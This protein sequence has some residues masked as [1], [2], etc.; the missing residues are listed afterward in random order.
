MT[1]SR[2]VAFPEVATDPLL[3]VSAVPHRRL[4]RAPTLAPVTPLRDLARLRIAI[5]TESWRPNVDGVVTRLD[6]TVR[7]LREAGHEV[8]VVAPSID[9]A[10]EELV[11]YRTPTLSLGWLYG[12][13]PWAIPGRVVGRA[14]REFEPDVVHVVNPVLMGSLALQYAAKRYPTVVSYHTDVSVYASMYHLGWIR[15][16]LHEV[17]RR[18][19]RRADIRLATSDVGSRQLGDLRIDDVELW[20]RGVDLSLFRPGRDGTAMRDRLCP[21]PDRTLVLYVGRL[22]REKGCERLLDLARDPGPYHVALVGDGPDRARLEELFAGTRATFAGV[23][24][25]EDLADAY[26]AADVFVFP[27]ETDTLGLVLLE[28]LASG[29]PVVAT[30]SPAA[31]TVLGACPTAI[32]VPPGSADDALAAAVATASRLPREAEPASPPDAIAGRGWREATVGLVA[33][34]RQAHHR[35]RPPRRRRF[36]R[37]LAV[38]VSNAAVDLGVFNF[39]VFVHP[40]RAAGTN[41]VYNTVAVLAAIL[42]S[43]FW[44]SRWT[45][46]DRVT[47]GEGRWR[48]RALFLAQ[49]GINLAVS[50]GVI[51]GLSLLLGR[52]R[53]LPATLMSNLSKVVA[54]FTA[55]AVSYI[56]MHFLVFQAHRPH[57]PADAA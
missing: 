24:Q 6:N 14:L 2:Q 27:S 32:L 28:A 8:I 25:G 52:G 4:R 30:E 12:G 43:Y 5:V 40:T 9:P 19:Y 41:V 55:S 34:Y 49:S 35:R 15:P 51:L 17:M 48:Q 23:L 42:N 53:G 3:P 38:G 57:P 37:F 7:E 18:V 22:A 56:L 21:D 47:R 50:D 46:A 10:L 16:A 20:G 26:A 33:H 1:L 44:N 54:M 31:K 13:R 45:F 11:Q 36:G 29:L 39:F